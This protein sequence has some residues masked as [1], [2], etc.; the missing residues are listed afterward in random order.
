M[1]RRRE[2]IVIDIREQITGPKWIK[3]DWPLN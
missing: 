1:F 2:K 3:M